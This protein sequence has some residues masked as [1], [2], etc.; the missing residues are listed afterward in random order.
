M[1]IDMNN[2]KAELKKKN[3]SIYE[4]SK[5]TEI[6]YSTV[7]D[8]VNGKIKIN[9]IKLGNA[10]KIANCLNISMED[11]YIYNYEFEV[12]YSDQF[13]NV[14]IGTCFAKDGK[15][16][17]RCKLHEKEIEQEIGLVNDSVTPFIEDFALWT[18]KD[19]VTR[20]LLERWE[21]LI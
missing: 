13:H 6:P 19:I 9:N 18:L 12:Q 20:D 8:I 1:D 21:E 3:L 14:H 5:R 7:N 16:F 10:V 15:Y 17:L 11:M 2:L 4:L